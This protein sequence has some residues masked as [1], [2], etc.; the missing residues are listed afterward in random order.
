LYV[1]DVG[2]H[3]S[4]SCGVDGRAERRV[5][6]ATS[7]SRVQPTTDGGRTSCCFNL[8]RAA[9]LCAARPGFAGDLG[10]VIDDCVFSRSMVNATPIAGPSPAER[11]Q[12]NRYRRC[13]S[14]AAAVG[15]DTA[16]DQ[17]P[18]SRRDALMTPQRPR[19]G[20]ATD[21]VHTA[22]CPRRRPKSPVRDK[23][24]RHVLD[25]LA[26]LLPRLYAAYGYQ[27]TAA[28]RQPAA[29]VT[30]PPALTTRPAVTEP[31]D[32]DSLTVSA[33]HRRT[34]SVLSRRGDHDRTSTRSI[35]R[36]TSTPST[37]KRHI[38]L[39]TDNFNAY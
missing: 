14:A 12:M 9:C 11:H 38:T 26:E 16:V 19:R 24:T 39:T 21:V 4:A 31:S 28:Y 8:R 35:K 10:G 23:V 34:T 15:R 33:I 13:R 37:T 2:Q 17:T 32:E 29:R 3:G 7:R 30:R 18:R 1:A 36:G 20:P 5:V 6:S 25:P 22:K 27:F